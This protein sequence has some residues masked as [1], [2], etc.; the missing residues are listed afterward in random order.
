M[1]TWR[2][3]E[4]GDLVIV[5]FDS[6]K[7]AFAG[8]TFCWGARFSLRVRCTFQLKGDAIPDLGRKK[9]IKRV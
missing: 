2:H 5:G 7:V 1:E 8:G 6:V 9:T 4:A 3:G